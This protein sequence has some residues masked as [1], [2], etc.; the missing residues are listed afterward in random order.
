MVHIS[1]VDAVDRPKEQPKTLSINC[2]KVFKTFMFENSDWQ[3]A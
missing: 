2:Y 1:S 3:I